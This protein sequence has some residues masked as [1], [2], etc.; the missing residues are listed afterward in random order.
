MDKDNGL[1]DKIEQGDVRLGFADR[2]TH[3]SHEAPSGLRHPVSIPDA[4]LLE[5][6]SEFREGILNGGPSNWMCAAICWP[7][8]SLLRAIYNVDCETIEFDAGACNH[9]W[10]KLAD[11]R[12]LDPTLDQFNLWFPHKNYPPVFLGPV[13]EYERIWGL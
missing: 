13:A 12:A 6:A 8:A 9:V 3:A 7:L 10:I 4:E 5:I 2:A 11:G 1:A